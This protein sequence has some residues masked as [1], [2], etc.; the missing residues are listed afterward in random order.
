MAIGECECN[1]SQTNKFRWGD[2]KQDRLLVV[3]DDLKARLGLLRSSVLGKRSASA[4]SVDDHYRVV[5]NVPS[6]P[7]YV[8]LG[9][10]STKTLEG[11]FKSKILSCG[12]AK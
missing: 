8:V 3:F 5:F 6:N 12:E 7:G 2:E 4:A 1:W 9:L 11:Q 10:G